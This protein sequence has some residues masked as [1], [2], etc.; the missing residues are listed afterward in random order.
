MPD[1]ENPAT[2][3]ARIEIDE[4]SIQMPAIQLVYKEPP[5]GRNARCS[6][7][8][9]KKFKKCHGDPRVAA[10]NR[11]PR[12]QKLTL[13]FAHPIPV[14]PGDTGQIGVMLDP[15]SKKIEVRS[16]GV[17]ITPGKVEIE[18][19]YA[20][21]KGPKVTATA[22][23]DGAASHFDFTGALSAYDLCIGIDTNAK[24]VNG[25]RICVTG[26]SIFDPAQDPSKRMYVLP[27]FA[28]ELRGVTGPP[29]KL[30]WL[31]LISSLMSSKRF[32]TSK[33][34]C[35]IVDSHLSELSAIA[36]R[37]QPILDEHFLPAP[38]DLTYAS[39]D[40]GD[41][42]QNKL[43]KYADW[44]ATTVLKL[45]DAGQQFSELDRTR[46]SYSE[47]KRIWDVQSLVRNGTVKLN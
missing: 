8:S 34:Y 43:I 42:L 36:Q 16:D 2:P 11:K 7:G 35:L 37:K 19:N 18:E 44:C 10:A 45:L 4:L 33:R 17:V 6:C 27:G 15:W 39:S 28:F 3:K 47:A 32:D 40:V 13:S 26:T 9:G 31:L 22:L 23:I 21:D 14:Q 24:E 5:G 20:R 46:D 30:G 1:P 38:F 29:E 12:Q 41:S 25:E